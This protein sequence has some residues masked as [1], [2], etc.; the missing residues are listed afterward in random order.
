MRLQRR[1]DEQPRSGGIYL[2]QGV[3]LG[4][5]GETI[6]PRSGD[7]CRRSAACFCPIRFPSAYALGYVDAAAPR[8]DFFTASEPR[9]RRRI[10]CR[11]VDMPQRSFAVFA[12]QDDTT[13]CVDFFTPFQDDTGDRKS[14]V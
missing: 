9:R 2:A 11:T 10:W 14:V 8:L 4:T 3:T 12:A 1:A 5:R 7:I 6:K 13:A